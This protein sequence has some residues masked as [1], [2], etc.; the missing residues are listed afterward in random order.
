MFEAGVS[1]SVVC[2]VCAQDGKAQAPNFSLFLISD[3]GL[4]K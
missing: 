2:G 3:C 4:S 1:P